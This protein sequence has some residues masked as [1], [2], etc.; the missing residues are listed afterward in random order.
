MRN[1]HY[2]IFILSICSVCCVNTIAQQTCSG[3]ILSIKGT[4]LLKDGKTNTKITQQN[5]SKIKPK[6]GQILMVNSK[7]DELRLKLDCANGE[8]KIIF[9]K[10]YEIPGRPEMVK[11]PGLKPEVW[12][13]G[14][15]NRHGDG[16][17][18]FPIES[19][20]IIAVVRPETAMLRWATSFPK[21]F[22]VSFVILSIQEKKAIW[23][24]SDIPGHVGNYT[25][26]KLKKVLQDI[27]E[28][29]PNA[30]LKLELKT[31]VGTENYATFRVFPIVKEKSLQ[32]EL[33]KLKAED[34]VGRAKIYYSYNLFIE[35]ANE[36]EEAL[37]LSPNSIDLLK[38]TSIAQDSAGNSKRRSELDERIKILQVVRKTK[39]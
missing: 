9:N 17:I 14:G 18:L 7:N 10:P 5:Y 1:F 11:G 27:Q 6:S 39:K 2:F 19:D 23:E 15:G 36:C 34:R 26:D 24:Q 25:N 8:V 37:K 35:A 4:G 13:D 32:Q 29:V 31:N 16:I 22:T 20:E 38:I 28:R 33:N 21:E 3:D 12:K 30:L